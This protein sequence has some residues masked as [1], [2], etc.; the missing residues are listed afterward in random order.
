L[1]VSSCISSRS[2]AIEASL[3][4]NHRQRWSKVTPRDL[5]DHAIALHETY[6]AYPIILSAYG[7]VMDGMHRVVKAL[8]Q[9]RDSIAALQFEVQPKPDF[10]NCRLKDLSYEETSP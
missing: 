9:G 7:R 1:P 8:M 4:R 5:I 6:L 3:S 2:G 10:R